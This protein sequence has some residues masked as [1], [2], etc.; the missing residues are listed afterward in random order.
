MRIL[1]F[2]DFMSC[3]EALTIHSLTLLT[4][5]GSVCVEVIIVPLDCGLEFLPSVFSL[6]Q[7]ERKAL[8]AQLLEAKELHHHR[9]R[10]EWPCQLRC[11]LPI[12]G[13]Y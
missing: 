11:C 13:G 1:G 3:S 6:G 4:I 9:R 10:R 7:I 12:D 5:A 8:H 2:M